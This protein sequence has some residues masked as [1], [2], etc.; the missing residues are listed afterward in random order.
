MEARIS[1]ITLGVD[2]LQKSYDFY[3]KIIGFTSEKGIENEAVAFFKLKN[4]LF[5]LYPKDKLADDALVPNEGSGFPGFTLAY[6][7]RSKEEVDEIINQ[8]HWAN[9]K[10]TKDPQD[11]FWGGYHAYFE[12][13]DGYLWEVAWN[14]FIEVE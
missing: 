7:V 3:S 12:D 13:P 11:A 8:L 2:N 10:V 6:N 9:V 1:M 14:P 4:I 5:S